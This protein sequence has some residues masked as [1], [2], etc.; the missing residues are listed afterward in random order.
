MKTITF[1]SYK[2][3]VGRTLA[4]VNIANRLA[5][6]GKKVCVMDFDLE[7]PGL[8]SKY[9]NGLQGKITQGLVDYIYSYACQHIIPKQIKAYTV[10]VD[11][12]STE[13]K[14]TFIP[15]GN[16]ADGNYWKK[17]ARI[18]WWDL[19]YAEHSYGIDF[20]LNLK[21][22]IE[23]ELKPDYL[24]IDSRTGITEMSSVTMSILADK[25][26]VL[27][28]NNEENIRGCARILDALT[29]EDNNLLGNEKEI[30]FVLTRIP[31]GKNPDERIQNEIKYNQ[32]INFIREVVKKNG[33]EL[34]STTKIYSDREL[35][36]NELYTAFY[37]YK[38][39]DS[40][41]ATKYF[42]LYVSLT[43]SDF[44]GIEG[45][46]FHEYQEYQLYINQA[47]EYLKEN[48]EEFYGYITDLIRKYPKFPRA[49]MLLCTYYGKK[50]DFE[51][52][53]TCAGEGLENAIAGQETF[54]FY[55]AV[56]NLY[57]NKLD[58]AIQAI[59][60]VKSNNLIEEFYRVLI[61]HRRFHN[62]EKDI[63]AVSKL[64]EQYPSDP[65]LYNQR[66]GYYRYYRQY[67]LA[68]K[69]VYRALEI[70][71]ESNLAYM[72]LAEIKYD[73]GDTEEFYRNMEMGLKY[74]F[75]MRQVKVDEAVDIYKSC[76][77][78]ERF[79]HLLRKYN[80]E[81]ILTTL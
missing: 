42:E 40:H 52:M 15:A 51:K 21:Q 9:A 3:G 38:T 69:D 18:N 70:N 6:S 76:R 79:I 53:L 24:L 43:Q 73:M 64:I 41:S 34:A 78:E 44:T 31:R 50:F 56:A 19:L 29:Q 62:Q 61:Y 20:F 81:A 8:D 26:V 71:T 65:D 23:D 30:H 60:K 4:L 35:E 33:K 2:G 28:A 36:K 55:L 10:E 11:K 5:E 54:H 74:K 72:T 63:A 14:L 45:K 57:L 47:E 37:T 39:S 17:L 32:K 49:Y 77:D 58:D 1:Y 22:Q 13:N 46:A 67:D 80:Q 7:A 27:A 66:A 12:F 48:K 59:D 16:T 68:L 75:D 25:I